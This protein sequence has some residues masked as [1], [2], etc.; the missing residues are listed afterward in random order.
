MTSSNHVAKSVGIFSLSPQA[1]IL[2]NPHLIHYGTL[3][4]NPYLAGDVPKGVSLHPGEGGA[5]VGAVG[6]VD[7]S[8]FQVE[9][10]FFGRFPV[11]VQVA[12]DAFVVVGGKGV[13][14]KDIVLVGVDAGV[15][16]VGVEPGDAELGF[17]VR[18]P[19]GVDEILI[20]Q[21][22]GL[23]DGGFPVVNVIE[24]GT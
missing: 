3:H 18:F 21:R 8:P 1:F 24:P 7:D 12:S 20:E 14:V 22:A 4:F 5:D 23:A 10:C 2:F 13:A 15:V 16:G 19:K 11:E 17:D 6:V 9:G